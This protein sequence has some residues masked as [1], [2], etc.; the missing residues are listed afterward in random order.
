MFSKA[1]RPFTRHEADE[2]KVVRTISE[3]ECPALERVFT[4]RECTPLELRAAYSSP[5]A[6]NTDDF[7]LAA[8]VYLCVVDKVKDEYMR[9]FDDVDAAFAYLEKHREHTAPLVKAVAELMKP[10]VEGGADSANFQ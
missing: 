10:R 9:V 8:L 6:S 1:S 5:S 2:F 7:A 3:V 4:L